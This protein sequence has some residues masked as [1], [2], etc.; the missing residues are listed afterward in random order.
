MTSFDPRPVLLRASLSQ[1]AAG[2][3][4]GV[5]ARTVR[6]WCSPPGSEWHRAMPGPAVRLLLL[7]ADCPGVVPFLEAM[8]GG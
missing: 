8:R 3:L 6:G 4:L 1:A 7:I 5:P 2:H